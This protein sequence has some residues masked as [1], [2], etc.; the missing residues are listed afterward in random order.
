MQDLDVQ[1]SVL[2]LN[3]HLRLNIDHI[4]VLDDVD[5]APF[6]IPVCTKLTLVCPSLSS[7]AIAIRI[8]KW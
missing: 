6:H 8:R 2:L 3:L 1:F 7:I 5:R 4:D